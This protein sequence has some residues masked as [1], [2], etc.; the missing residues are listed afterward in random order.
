MADKKQTQSAQ[1]LLGDANREGAAES[2]TSRRSPAEGEEGKKRDSSLNDSPT[3]AERPSTETLHVK[4]VGKFT[5]RTARIVD[6][7]ELV[8]EEPKWDFHSEMKKSDNLSGHKKNMSSSSV[9]SVD[10][11]GKSLNDRASRDHDNI[12]HESLRTD[13]ESGQVCL[14]QE[15]VKELEELQDYIGSREELGDRENALYHYKTHIASNIHLVSFQKLQVKNPNEELRS[16][17]DLRNFASG[18][19]RSAILLDIHEFTVVDIAEVLIRSLIDHGSLPEGSGEDAKFALFMRKLAKHEHPEYD[20]QYSGLPKAS[21][22]QNTVNTNNSFTINNQIDWKRT[23]TLEERDEIHRGNER[24]KERAGTPFHLSIHGDGFIIGLGRLPV[25]KQRVIALARLARP[26]LLSSFTNSSR[27]RFVVIVLGPTRE[28]K[29][30]KSIVETGNTFA[31]LLSENVFHSDAIVAK[32]PETFQYFILNYIARL[33]LR[34]KMIEENNISDANAEQTPGSG[35][36]GEKH[37]G[38]LRFTGKFAGGLREDFSRRIQVYRSDFTDGLNEWSSIVKYIVSTVYVFLACFIPALA[39]GALWNSNTNGAIGVT[40]IVLSEAFCGIVFSLLGGQP[41]MVLRSSGPIAIFGAVVYNWSE[42]L[43]VEFLPFY[44][45]VG[46]WSAVLMII[47]S[48]TDASTFIL[49]IGTFT[50]EAFALLISGIFIETAIEHEVHAYEHDEKADFLLSLLLFIGT[51]AIAIQL[52]NFKRSLYLRPSV[53]TFLSDFGPTIAIIAM[54]GF[55]QIMSDV[56]QETL[57]SELPQEFG[58]ITTSGRAWVVDVFSLDIAYIFVALLPAIPLTMI[59]YLDQNV[60]MLLISRPRNL[61]KKGPAF[62]WDMMISGILIFFSSILG[63][64]WCHGALP[65]SLLHPRSLADIEEYTKF[66]RLYER[67]IRSREVRWANLFS[68]ILMAV[69]MLAKPMLELIPISVLY[70]YFLYLGIISLTGNAM[71]ER[72]LLLI[73][74]KE[75]YPPNHFVRRVPLRVIHLFTIVQIVCFLVLWFVHGNFYIDGLIIPPAMFFPVVVF[76]LIPVRL[77]ILPKLFD[78]IYIEILTEDEPDEVDHY[79]DDSH[80]M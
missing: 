53:R 34:D 3:A 44:S 48:V 14:T 41:L 19:L 42:T 38:Y 7:A 36:G 1:S 25:L 32:T 13:E 78:P 59:F 73:T 70:G 26:V 75:K 63:T 10:K 71:W 64:P 29:A 47:L 60:S 35:R 79:D 37:L 72:V 20:R 2:S 43:K 54:V 22:T 12:S 67:V 61:L 4:N 56:H 23:V 76:L 17:K 27:V 5:V 51:Y 18:G 9:F 66:G 50:E 15:T 49:K 74:Q 80:Y 11:D 52:L 62:H 8:S 68:H 65:H 31:S 16:S 30:T 28:D 57:K 77:Y 39:F 6:E 33:E 69:A 58:F 21:S 45:W 46:I 40:E 55:S 24:E